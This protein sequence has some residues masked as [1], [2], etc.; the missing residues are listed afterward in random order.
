M[1]EHAPGVEPVVIEGD[2]REASGSTAVE[3]LRSRG[4]EFDGIVAANDMMALGV[5]AALRE[6]DIAVPRAVAVTGFDDV[7]LARY[8][9]LTT[10]RVPI[11]DMG[12]RAV[13]RLIDALDDTPLTD[14]V[15]TVDTELVV[16]TT[17]GS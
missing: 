1:A 7:P 15:E 2:F 3:L 16:R 12:A 9:G 8:L 13:A 10:V 6:A 4:V 11:A 5:M 17:T 14:D